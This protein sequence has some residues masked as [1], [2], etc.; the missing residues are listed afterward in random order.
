MARDLRRYA[1]DTNTRLLIGFLLILFLVGDGLIWM[2]Y[3]REAA[4]FGVLCLLAALFPLLLIAL[5][6]WAIDFLLQRLQ[7]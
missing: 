5:A 7:E 4:V 3:G 2:I 6:L 1:R